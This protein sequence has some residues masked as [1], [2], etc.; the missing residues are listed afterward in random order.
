MDKLWKHYTKWKKS[1]TKDHILCHLHEIPR[2][3]KSI[4]R[5]HVVSQCSSF[6]Q[7]MS[8][9]LW[10]TAPQASLSITNSWSLLRLMS[11]ESVMLSYCLILCHSLSSIFLSIRVFSNE[12][13]L[14]I[15]WS[16]YWSFSFSISPSVNIQDWLLLG[17]TGWISCCSRD[18]QESSPTPQFKSINY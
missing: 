3:S 16:K 12:S 7:V 14:F 5:G 6:G 8:A 9:I 10:T 4:K 2:V 13:V 15:M 11:I 18:S 1:G 17:L